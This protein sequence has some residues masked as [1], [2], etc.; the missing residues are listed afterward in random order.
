MNIKHCAGCAD[1]FYNGNNG[2]GVQRC[3]SFD[4]KK[5]LVKRVRIGLWENPPYLNKKPVRVPPCYHERGNQ[6]DIFVAPE[7]IIGGYIR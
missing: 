7:R 2:L 5:K 1:N 3:W 4:A 6:R